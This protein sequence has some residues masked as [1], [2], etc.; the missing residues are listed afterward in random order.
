MSLKEPV[1]A[2]Y[3][4][5]I[6]GLL[7]GI[8]FVNALA[9]TTRLRRRLAHYV[10]RQLS[11]RFLVHRHSFLGPWNA[12]SLLG[13]TVYVGVN[14]FC[15]LFRQSATLS[16][17]GTLT[18][19]NLAPLFLG[20][21]LGF[22]ADLLGI[23]LS[24]FMFWHRW[25]GRV[26]SGML[27]VHIFTAMADQRPVGLNQTKDVLGF[28]GSLSAVSA[29]FCFLPFLRHHLYELCLRIHQALA[30]LVAA[31]V[32][33]HLSMMTPS[34]SWLWLYIYL[35]VA[36][37]LL[38]AQT[39]LTAYRNKMLGR[40][41]S[42][43]IVN[44]TTGTVLVSVELSRPISV[45]AGQYITLWIPRIGLLESHPFVVTSWDEAAQ[46]TLELFI[47]PR[48]GFTSRLLR[49]SDHRAIPHLAFFSGP[50]GV[51]VPVWDYEAVFMM[52]TDHGIAAL[53]PYLRKLVHGYNNCKGRTRQIHLV[54]QVSSLGKDDAPLRDGRLTGPGIVHAAQSF[55]NPILDDDTLDQG[56]ILD[57]SI[58]YDMQKKG[59][60]VED[61]GAVAPICAGDE[62]LLE[63]PPMYTVTAST[64][65]KLLTKYYA[66]TDGRA[67]DH[68]TRVKNFGDRARLFIGTP[69]VAESLWNEA[70]RLL[71]HSGGQASTERGD[72]LLLGEY[73][74]FNRNTNLISVAVSAG[75]DVRDRL[76]DLAADFPFDPPNPSFVASG[77]QE[78]IRE[79]LGKKV[80][81][82]ELDFQPDD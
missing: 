47:K 54:W 42:R 14:V 40:T 81:L 2:A 55:L 35:I 77:Q 82:R 7:V 27:V 11:Y 6:A 28:V 29:A 19:L 38:L 65:A 32:C 31:G 10:E 24:H 70:S 21:S 49:Y 63:K 34:R 23:S 73:H 66:P 44:H 25:Q 50:H 71:S 59:M 60:T 62:S 8:A 79:Y 76:H 39:C 46:N 51:S 52:A 16:R 1:T 56:Y 20:P 57:I 5:C 22:V 64:I 36:A 33:L 9:R 61:L 41:F 43:A 18:L 72:M 58:Y 78:A 4:I 67:G 3:A 69:D 45:E 53:V 80:W 74:G 26:A 15:F 48:R 68:P 37:I 17:S 75:A 30:C 13:P 12:I